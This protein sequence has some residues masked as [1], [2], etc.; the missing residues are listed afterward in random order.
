MIVDEYTGIETLKKSDILS[1]SIQVV[2]VL[3]SYKINKSVLQ[4]LIEKAGRFWEVKPEMEE[5][6]NQFR[7]VRYF[8]VFYKSAI[9]GTTIYYEI[10]ALTSTERVLPTECYRFCDIEKDSC[11]WFLVLFVNIAAFVLVWGIYTFDGFFA[12][13]VIQL[14]GQLKL[15]KHKLENLKF[16]ND[17]ENLIEIIDHHNFILDFINDINTLYSNILFTQFSSLIFSMCI[18]S[19][20]LTL[21]GTPTVNTLTQYVVYLTCMFTQVFVFSYGGQVILDETASVADVAYQTNWFHAS[22][23]MQK[24]ISTII[25]RSQQETKISVGGFSNLDLRMYLYVCC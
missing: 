7:L 20:L 10:A 1:P 14:I 21:H 17:E 11:Y 25:L 5:I 2:I 15:I 4:D 19:F 24:S 9:L 12:G 6:Q 16:E 8:M 23:S 22:V 3:L 13:S 18:G